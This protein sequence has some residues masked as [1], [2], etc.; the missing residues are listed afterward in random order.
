MSK[1]HLLFHRDVLTIGAT[2]FLLHIHHGLASCSDCAQIGSFRAPSDATVI[3]SEPVYNEDSLELQRRKELNK[4][5]K[6]YGL[7]VECR[8]TCTQTC[9]YM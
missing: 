1:P 7:R 6:K 4:I 5:K 2:P 9:T 8:V 3:S